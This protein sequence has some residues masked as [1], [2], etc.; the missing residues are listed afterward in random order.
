[1]VGIE[2]R[3]LEGSSRT[4]TT[5]MSSKRTYDTKRHWWSSQKTKTCC[6]KNFAF[7]NSGYKIKAFEASWAGNIVVARHVWITHGSSP[8]ERK[9]AKVQSPSWKVDIPNQ[10]FFTNKRL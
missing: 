4:L 8:K 7:L 3:L 5:C 6:N 10:H 1:M 2:W 9:N